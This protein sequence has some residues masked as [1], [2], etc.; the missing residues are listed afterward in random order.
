MNYF[1]LSFKD[2]AFFSTLGSFA[3]PVIL[4]NLLSASLNFIDVFM[5]G[6]LGDNAV[7]AVGAANQ[8]FFFYMMLMFG[9]ASG[10]GIFVA[11]FWGKKDI[12]GIHSIMGIS[13]WS[14]LIPGALF[15]ILVYF[16]PSSIMN[17]FTSDQDV[18]EIGSQYLIIISLSYL[19]LPI[20]MNYAVIM[21]STGEVKVPMY[22]SFI[23]VSINTVGNYCLIFGNYGFAELGVRGAAIATIFARIV[24]LMILLIYAHSKKNAAALRTQDLLKINKKMFIK[25]LQ[26][27]IPI[28]LQGAG[29]SFGYTVYSIIYGHIGTESFAA[30]NLA[31]SIERICLILFTGFGVACSIMVGNSIGD[32]NTDRARKYA[33]NILQLTVA[34]ALI[35]GALL[36]LSKEYL[37]SLYK[38]TDSG[39]QYLSGILLV[40]STI[41]FA[42]AL[43][44]VFHMGVFK[45]GGDTTFSMVV[46]V[47]G[48]WAIGIPLAATGAFLFHLPVHIVVA[49]AGAEEITKVTIAVFRFFS[50]KWIHMLFDSQSIIS[51]ENT[52]VT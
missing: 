10:A 22:A 43:N 11:Q 28:I 35:I 32:N 38:V 17:I 12:D 7:A 25:Y 3:V 27:S 23:G 37:I 21:R 42:K 6:R 29:W 8:F 13:T 36:F 1:M 18:V 14:G 24:E 50:H 31:C 34:S 44:I 51:K 9:V 2:K 16:F 48:I 45:A 52:V 33:S 47:G 4:Q 39:R 5:I 46:D 41:L 26:I 30:Y 15:F 19:L 20:G 40:M 49:M